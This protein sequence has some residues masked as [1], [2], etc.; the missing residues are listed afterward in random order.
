MEL[1]KSILNQVTKDL[2]DDSYLREQYQ[3]VEDIKSGKRKAYTLEEF[4]DMFDE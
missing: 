1:E 4:C 3:K 2:K